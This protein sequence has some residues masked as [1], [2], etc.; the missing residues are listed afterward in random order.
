MTDATNNPPNSD[1][2][3]DPKHRDSLQDQAR[4]ESSRGKVDNI[5]PETEV[6]RAQRQHQQGDQDSRP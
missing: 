2:S 5:S 3:G 6:D 4:Q 1:Q